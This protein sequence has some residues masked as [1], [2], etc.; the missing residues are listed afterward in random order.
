MQ[1]LRR[2]WQLEDGRPADALQRLQSDTKRTRGWMEA[3]NL[4]HAEPIRATSN[5]SNASEL[6]NTTV[7]AIP[8]TPRMNSSN[9]FGNKNLRTRSQL[10]CIRCSVGGFI[11]VLEVFEGSF[12]V[13]EAFEVQDEAP[14][15][16]PS[17]PSKQLFPF[18]AIESRARRFLKAWLCLGFEAFKAFEGFEKE[19]EGGFEGFEG[20]KGFEAFE[21]IVAAAEL[22]LQVALKEIP[23]PERCPEF[24]WGL[25]ASLRRCRT[26]TLATSR[27]GACNRTAPTLRTSW[28]GFWVPMHKNDME[29]LI[30]MST[31][32]FGAAQRQL[33]EQK[34]GGQ[35]VRLAQWANYACFGGDGTRGKILY[36]HGV[37]VDVATEEWRLAQS[38]TRMSCE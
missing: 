35:G 32:N 28:H 24:N 14:S 20:E 10:Q 22:D 21:T 30:W 8:A 1:E 34:L 3:E 2:D 16:S 12:E 31:K 26:C 15:S 23:D 33:L 27:C 7:R 9:K 11:F 29:A 5:H 4:S 36:S 38:P 37:V 17:K 25:Q 6:L 13:F 19:N 18:E